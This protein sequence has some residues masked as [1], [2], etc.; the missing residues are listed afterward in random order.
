MCKEVDNDSNSSNNSSKVKNRDPK[1]LPVAEKPVTIPEN[2]QFS[3]P[4]HKASYIN[5]GVKI[6][7]NEINDISFSSSETPNNNDT[8][9]NKNISKNDEKSASTTY[10][11]DKSSD[12]I[13]AQKNG[14]ENQKEERSTD[15]YS[16]SNTESEHSYSDSGSNSYSSNSKS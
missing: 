10:D 9:D 12:D 4:K 1:V 14:E 7:D 6:D 8:Q 11:K 15:D 5:N 2:N 13:A 16:T 3:P